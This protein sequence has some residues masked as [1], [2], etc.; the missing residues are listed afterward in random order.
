MTFPSNSD[1]RRALRRAQATTHTIS[2]ITDFPVITTAATATLAASATTVAL[3]PSAAT[4][5]AGAR[6][7][8]TDAT[9]TTFHS[10]VAGGGANKVPVVSDG[11]NWLIG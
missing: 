7:F 9:A 6:N 10:T 8:V 3:L 5:G 11:T 2:E 1:Q 4:V